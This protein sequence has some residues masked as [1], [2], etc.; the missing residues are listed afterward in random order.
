M[1]ERKKVSFELEGRP[2][3]RTRVILNPGKT[4]QQLL[5]DLETAT[6]SE[7][8]KV[9]GIQDDDGCK[10]INT[11]DILT[12]DRLIVTYEPKAPEVAVKDASQ[13]AQKLSAVKADAP[14]ASL[15]VAAT[16]TSG[17][18]VDADSA[19]ESQVLTASRMSDFV[20]ERVLGGGANGM[21][22]AARCIRKG[23][24]D[25]TKLYALK[26]VFNFGMTTHQTR[27]S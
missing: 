16:D 11:E 27:N 6:F 9:T 13:P 18:D 5:A 19:V 23:I 15:P 25:K 10:I 20:L 26:L 24:P 4:Y 21:V 1:G 12:G 7:S 2:D 22:F 3:T 17:M 14:Q 8:I